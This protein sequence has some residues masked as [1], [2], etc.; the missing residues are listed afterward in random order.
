MRCDRNAKKIVAELSV[1][2][3][4]VP[5]RAIPGFAQA[6]PVALVDIATTPGD[7]GLWSDAVDKGV[8]LEQVLVLA[9]GEATP[10]TTRARV[11]AKTKS[12]GRQH[13]ARTAPRTVD[14]LEMLHGGWYRP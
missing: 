12:R 9:I 11:N 14:R 1:S 6:S 3:P 2:A 8:L 13:H 7:E 5:R 4:S 10:G